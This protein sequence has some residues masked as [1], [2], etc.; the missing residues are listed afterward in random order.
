[1][2][3]KKSKREKDCTEKREESDGTEENA[4]GG[5]GAGAAGEIT[6]SGKEYERL[7]ACEKERDEYK[8]KYLR[9]HAEVDNTLKRM[10]K[11]RE[12]YVKFANED[13]I[14]ELLYVMDNFDR[15]LGHM[16]GSRKLESVIEGIKMIQKQFHLLLEARG[17]RKIESV[18]QNFDPKFHDAVEHVE[19]EN[20]MKDKVVE[21]VQTGY[22]LNERLLR[23][24]SVK[25]GKG[26]AE[27]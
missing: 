13:L 3:G 23:P 11:S 24:A 9:A 10:T 18:G 4:G 14:S 5:S 7:L 26:Q 1:M 19:S 20:E 17:V 21:E 12:D 8:D 25:V 16:D 15:A 27:S 6:I 22:L 2:T